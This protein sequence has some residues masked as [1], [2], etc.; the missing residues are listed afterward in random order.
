MNRK[1]MNLGVNTSC[2]DRF[3]RIVPWMES[4]DRRERKQGERQY[5]DLCNEQLFY[6]RNKYLPR[7]VVEE[8]L[9]G[10]IEYLPQLDHEGKPYPDHHRTRMIDPVWLEDYPRIERAFSVDKFYDLEDPEQRQCLVK[11]IRENLKKARFG[12]SA[13]SRRG[14]R[15]A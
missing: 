15:E 1:Q 11:R 12:S 4:G 3:Q 14:S 13:P 7:E 10:K 2:N 8:W 6:F 5:V 9:D